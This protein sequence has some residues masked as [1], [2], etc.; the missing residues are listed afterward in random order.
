MFIQLSQSKAKQRQPKVKQA[1]AAFSDLCD[2]IR[3]HAE[4]NSSARGWRNKSPEDAGISEIVL[5]MRAGESKC[6][7]SF[8]STPKQTVFLV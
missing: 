6:F 3:G 1:K 4:L 7:F 2:A 8:S 5:A